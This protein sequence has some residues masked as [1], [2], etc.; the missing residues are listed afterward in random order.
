MRRTPLLS[1]KL[2]LMIGFTALLLA[3]LADWSVR[4]LSET[5]ALNAV[6]VASS[7]VSEAMDQRFFERMKDVELLAK[8][9]VLLSDDLTQ[10]RS[11]LLNFRGKDRAIEVCVLFDRNG[12]VLVDSSG[13]NKVD[14]SHWPWFQAAVAGETAVSAVH[15]SPVTKRNVIAILTPVRSPEGEVMRVVG[16]IVELMDLQYSLEDSALARA[17]EAYLRDPS[18]QVILLGHPGG[19]PTT[20]LNLVQTI[21]AADLNVGRAGIGTYSGM[22]GRL[23]AG[24][25]HE[26]QV[27]GWSVIIEQDLAV[28]LQGMAS[29]RLWSVVGAVAFAFAVVGAW[30]LIF[31]PRGHDRRA[32]SPAP[33]GESPG[34][35]SARTGARQA[36]AEI[37]GLSPRESEILLHVASGMTN[38]EIANK[39]FL[40]EHTVKAHLHRILGKLELE[41]RTQAA[42]YALRHLQPVEER[43]D[44]GAGSGS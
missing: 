9:G 13:F 6:R 1:T 17:G 3:A 26:M 22:M 30:L 14:Y 11:Y 18:G 43:S 4:S 27:P 20:L 23:V 31:Q 12:N 38:R 25:Y 10:I 5:M 41:N 37:E 32:A 44:S 39:L 36:M 15:A 24:A 42:A 28:A 35:V 33:V 21:A 34:T 8:Q 7:A 16:T 2:F 19:T 29:L 40:S